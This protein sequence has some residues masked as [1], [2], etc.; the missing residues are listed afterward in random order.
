MKRFFIAGVLMILAISVAMASPHD[1]EKEKGKRD[2][3]MKELQEFKM[4]FLA[5]E[6]GLNESQKKKFFE[7]YQSME[8][9]KGEILKPVW[10]ME[11]ELKKEKNPSEQ[12]YQKVTEAKKK[13]NVECSELDRIY[14][15]KFSEFLTQKQIY[16]LKEGEKS[17]REKL[18]EMRH[19]RKKGK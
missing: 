4:K 14:D 5:D 18:E 11:R 16:K 15:E 12:D 10:K 19:K 8:E 3:M 2:K 13:A 6:M 17:F 7:L 1:E 9:K